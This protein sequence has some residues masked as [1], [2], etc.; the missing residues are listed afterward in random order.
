MLTAGWVTPPSALTQ[1]QATR[2][3]MISDAVLAPV[4]STS[5]SS[6]SELR[7]GKPAP[8]RSARAFGVV[9]VVVALWLISQLLTALYFRII[10]T[11]LPRQGSRPEGASQPDSPAPG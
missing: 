11:N 8:S 5:A 3:L 4:G 10:A 9:A 1:V 7:P 6:R 2:Y